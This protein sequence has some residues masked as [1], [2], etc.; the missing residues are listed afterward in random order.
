MVR[1]IRR[2]LIDAQPYQP[3][4]SVHRLEWNTQCGF[5]PDGRDTVLALLSFHMRPS[6][7]SLLIISSQEITRS[8]TL[9]SKAAAS[10]CQG[11]L[12]KHPLPGYGPVI[13]ANRPEQIRVPGGAGT[14]INYPR[15]HG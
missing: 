5:G 1:F 15:L 10:S 6:L 2:S 14:G 7:Y 9:S 3:R 8:A 11:A 12:N 4:W 13:S